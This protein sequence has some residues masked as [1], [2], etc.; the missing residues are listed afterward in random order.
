MFHVVEYTYISISNMY[1]ITGFILL[2]SFCA[3]LDI[4][5]SIIKML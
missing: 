3:N 5:H 2:I 4:E 1:I